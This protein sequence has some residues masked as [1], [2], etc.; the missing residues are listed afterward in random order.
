MSFN[1][2]LFDYCARCGAEHGYMCG[3]CDECGSK[4]FRHN[5]TPHL[6]AVRLV[7][8][9]SNNQLSQV[10]TAIHSGSLRDAKEVNGI[11]PGDWAEL[12]YSEL[13]TVRRLVV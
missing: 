6:K 7:K 5:L 2:T 4:V 13:N 8:E 10:W 1:D 12:V 3:S 9:M 11:P